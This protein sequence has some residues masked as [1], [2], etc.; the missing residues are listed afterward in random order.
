MERDSGLP[1]TGLRVDGGA[2]R[3]NMLMQYQADLLGVPVERPAVTETT[4]F[5]AAALAGMAVGFWESA[6]EAA[7][8]WRLERRFEPRM[9]EGRRAELLRDWHRAVERSRDWARKEGI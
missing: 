3:N 4:A 8:L 2:S 1:L 6:E 7:S 9:D 5:G